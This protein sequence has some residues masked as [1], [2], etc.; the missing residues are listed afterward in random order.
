MRA[1][2]RG[3][4]GVVHQVRSQHLPRLIDIVGNESRCWSARYRKLNDAGLMPGGAALRFVVLPQT[5]GIGL[6]DEPKAV[7]GSAPG[8]RLAAAGDHHQWSRR[9]P[10]GRSDANP[11]AVILDRFA[12]HQ[13]AEH[14]Q[15]LVGDP[16]TRR[17]VQAEMF[18][19]LAAVADTKHIRHPASADEIQ[20][21]H[22]LGQPYR[23]PERN[24]HRGKEN[25]QLLCS[26]GDRRGQDQRGWQMAVVGTVV[27][28]Q[29]GEDRTAGL[30]PSAHVDGCGIEFG[31]RR[32][33][34]GRSHVEPE[35]EHRAQ[36]NICSPLL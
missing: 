13:T 35:R 36:P 16:A 15:H 30:R 28:G 31:G 5:R 25:R 4:H 2:G 14:G 3:G 23:I 33:P 10:A 27:L 1:V 18:V 21:G 24:R 11:A 7:R 19:L 20:D 22:L 32:G 26:R 8:G 29:D 34:I 12:A 17:D 6:R 9:R